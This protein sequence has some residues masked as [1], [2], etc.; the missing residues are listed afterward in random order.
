[1]PGRMNSWGEKNSFSSHIHT[2]FLMDPKVISLPH[3]SCS[4][5]VGTRI[6]MC[7][8]LP[9]IWLWRKSALAVLVLELWSLKHQVTNS[10][11]P[12]C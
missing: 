1:M 8:H 2:Q 4:S 7:L 3:G 12:F 5:K 9:K 11:F 10:R 6:S